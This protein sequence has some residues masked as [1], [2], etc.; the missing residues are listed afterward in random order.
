MGNIIHR[1]LNLAVFNR[2]NAVNFGLK[3]AV[4]FEEICRNI[5]HR[6]PI[7]FGKPRNPEQIDNSVMTVDGKTWY[8]F[9]DDSLRELFP[10]MALELV[11]LTLDEIEKFGG[12]EVWRGKNT[13]FVWIHMNFE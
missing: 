9:D 7:D 4:V 12:F 13:D 2:N 5:A 3:F 1:T 8:R 10:Y 6:E 11:K